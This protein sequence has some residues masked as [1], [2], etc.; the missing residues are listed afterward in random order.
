MYF[1]I[2]DCL[3]C[4]NTEKIQTHDLTHKTHLQYGDYIKRG[5]EIMACAL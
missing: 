2:L 1:L 4:A 3:S 5:F